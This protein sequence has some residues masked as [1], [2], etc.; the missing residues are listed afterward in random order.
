MAL[1]RTWFLHFEKD[2]TSGSQ[3]VAESKACSPVA[4]LVSGSR[5]L[6]SLDQGGDR[7]RGG[8][9]AKNFW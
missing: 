6:A 1:Q 3:T 2:R 7:L 5:R 9:V 4:T 8:S